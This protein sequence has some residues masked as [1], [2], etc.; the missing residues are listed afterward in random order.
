MFQKMTEKCFRKCV[1]KPG[2]SLDN[3]EQVIILF[4]KCSKRGSQICSFCLYRS[5]SPC[6]WTGT[7]TPGT[8]S[9]ELTAT[10]S[11][12][13]GGRCD[14]R[15]KKFHRIHCAQTPVHMNMACR[16]AIELPVL[17]SYHIKHLVAPSRN[18][19]VHHREV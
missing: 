8:L 14:L 9:Q 12:E 2:S 5:A 17:V 16:Y 10:E 15:N 18:A 13:K 11:P 7:W 1:S 3:S 4:H 6:A 19:C